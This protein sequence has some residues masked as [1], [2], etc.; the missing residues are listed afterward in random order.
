MAGVRGAIAS[1]KSVVV[2]NTTSYTMSEFYASVTGASTWDTTNNLIAGQTI[3]PGQTITISIPDVSGAGCNYDLMAV[4]YGAAQF[5]YQYQVDAC[6]AGSWT[7]K[8]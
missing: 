4:L 1:T 6:D 2:T 5:A 8:P 7:I 3:S